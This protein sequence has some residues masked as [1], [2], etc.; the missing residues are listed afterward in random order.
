M[1]ALYKKWRDISFIYKMLGALILGLICGLIFGEKI[2]CIKWIGTLFTNLLQMAALPLIFFSLISGVA[3]LDDPQLLGRIG[4]K[5]MAYYI[6]TTLFAA[7]FGSFI[8]TVFAPGSG[9]TLTAGY[10]AAEV[11]EMTAIG[12]TLLSMIPTNIFS[13]LSSGTLVGAIV[14]GTFAGIA[15]VLMKDKEAQQR[16]RTGLKDLADLLLRLVEMILGLAPFGVFALIANTVGTNGA[17]VMGFIAKYTVTIYSCLLFMVV[18]YIVLVFLFTHITPIQ[19]LR[20][21]LPSFITAFSTC[22]SLASMPMNLKCAENF[23]LPRKIYGFTIPLGA[24]INKDGTAILITSA[25]LAA[26]QAAGMSMGLGQMAQMV[27]TVLII[28]TG[29]AGVPGGTIVLLT[30]FST[31]FGFP[32]EVA[33]IIMGAFAIIEMGITASNI[34]GDLAGTVIVAYPE[35]KDSEEFKTAMAS[36][37]KS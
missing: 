11:G 9:L 31:T 24:Q 37:K 27:I 20:R 25:C 35:C 2:S 1:K 3:S 17:E 7:V 29:I 34:I 30:L 33:A 28:T 6:L 16:L 4:L 13:A 12:D 18:L 32:T 21:A 14:F 15:I 8:T 19:F 5:I 36:Y 22:S 23:G 10:E 26:G